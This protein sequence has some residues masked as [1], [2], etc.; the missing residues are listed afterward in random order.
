M[1]V[2]AL[3][4]YGAAHTLQEM[5]TIKS[6]DV[7]GR[8]KAYEAIVKGDDITK[9]S[10]PESFNVLVHELRALGMNVNLKS[11]SDE[12]LDF[13]QIVESEENMEDASIPEEDQISEIG[14]NGDNQETEDEVQEELQG[15]SSGGESAEEEM[16]DS[17]KELEEGHA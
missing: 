4:A 5:L 15:E 6:D 2:W 16:Q 14:H 13:D 12:S 3:E 8:S 11:E 7:V 17:L 1:E 9:P 10:T